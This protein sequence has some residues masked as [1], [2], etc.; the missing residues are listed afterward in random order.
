MWDE[1]RSHIAN[2][3]VALLENVNTQRENVQVPI[4]HLVSM[5]HF[6]SSLTC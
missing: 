3:A 1:A 2:T 6:T 5:L 4:E